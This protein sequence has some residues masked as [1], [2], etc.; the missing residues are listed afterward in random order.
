MII[1]AWPYR[2]YKIFCSLNKNDQTYF[3]LLLY[4]TPLNTYSSYP[5][6]TCTSPLFTQWFSW[7]VCR[8]FP[9]TH[10]IGTP[11]STHTQCVITHALKMTSKLDQLFR[12]SV[13]LHF[14]KWFKFTQ[15]L[16]II[17]HKQNNHT[18]INLVFF[19]D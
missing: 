16:S 14:I 10:C 11:H 9:H 3:F 8:H 7:L 5:V 13:C 18:H 19:Y 1:L 6:P 4:L 12:R 15:N 17:W 2:K